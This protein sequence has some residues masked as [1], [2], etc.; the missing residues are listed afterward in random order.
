[1]NIETSISSNFNSFIQE[2][3]YQYSPSKNYFFETLKNCSSSI[4]T[5]KITGELY[6]RYQS[7]CHATR[8]MIYH[9]PYLDSPDLRIRK[10]KFILDDDSLDFHRVHHYQLKELFK[11]IGAENIFEE[12]LFESFDL[13]CSRLDPVTISTV[14]IIENLY[15][16]N[17]G[18]WCI[19]EN[20]ADVWMRLLCDS[21]SSH[22]NNI[23]E[24]SYFYD[25]FSYEIEQRHAQ[26]SLELTCI[27]LEKRPKLLSETK[28]SAE[29][30]AK[31]I[32]RFWDS[33]EFLISPNLIPEN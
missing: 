7:F 22:F 16:K 25:A 3:N 18:A 19:V 27:A 31:T 33:L 24:A 4:L 20:F 23:S 21:L 11:S 13:L 10:I 32:S 17:L 9:I 29:N 8:V 28:Y 2:L 26:E 14:R 15:P 1:M 30:M 12:T 5:P 6:N